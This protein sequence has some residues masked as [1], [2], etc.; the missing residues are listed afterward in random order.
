MRT[1]RTH[2]AGAPWAPMHAGRPALG[3]GGIAVPAHAPD[4]AWRWDRNLYVEPEP[5]PLGGCGFSQDEQGLERLNCGLEGRPGLGQQY[6]R[7][8]AEG[9]LR[10]DA[11]AVAKGWTIEDARKWMS[12][13]TRDIEDM[14]EC[15]TEPVAR[16][17]RF[18]EFYDAGGFAKATAIPILP[19]YQ[20]DVAAAQAF[21]VC[22]FN[23]RNP[24]SPAVPGTAGAGT[25]SAGKRELL[26]IAAGLIAAG[27]LAW[28]IFSD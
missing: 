19:L 20:D 15:W 5:G 2:F 28:A 17:A 18:V 13:R 11:G 10:S 7:A 16:I 12:E 25:A 4:T 9:W 1:T 22:T 8:F 21:D 23:V 14:P 24:G 26:M 3:A 6:P 27:G